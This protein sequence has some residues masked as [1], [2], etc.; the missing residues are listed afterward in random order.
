MRSSNASGRPHDEQLRRIA[1]ARRTQ[2]DAVVGKV[3]IEKVYA[4]RTK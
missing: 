3:E 2:C 4:H 1:R